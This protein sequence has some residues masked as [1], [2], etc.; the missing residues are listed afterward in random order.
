MRSKQQLT[1]AQQ[2]FRNA[3]AQMAAAVNI[4]T[5]Y[6]SA[7]TCG[8]TATAV[9]SITDTPPTVLVCVNR[10]SQMNEVFQQNKQ[11][12]INVLSAEQEELAYHF[13]GMRESSM[14][15][16]FRMEVW[17]EKDEL[18]H[19]P[20]LVGSLA[21]LHGRIT[22]VHDVGTHSLFFVTIDKI[23]I[24]EGAGLVYFNRTFQTVK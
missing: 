5:T 17:Q 10:N 8:L 18:E 24:H 16:R 7:G 11:V 1:P 3:M 23:D 20:A 21:N 9:C 4:V 19:A 22:A 13:A 15:E 2:N 12:C 6:G 14:E